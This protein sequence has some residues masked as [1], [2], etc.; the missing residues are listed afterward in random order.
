MTNFY[1]RPPRGGRQVALFGLRVR[2]FISIHALREEGD[3]APANRQ[4]TYAISIHAL[5]EEG[6]AKLIANY[7]IG[8]LF[9]STPS[10]RRA[11]PQNREQ[12]RAA[13][14]FLSTPSARRATCKVVMAMA[15]TFQFL[16]TPSARRATV[17]TRPHGFRPSHF[18]PRPP[19]GGRPPE[20]PPSARTSDF[21]PRPPRGGRRYH[22]Y[23]WNLVDD[24]SIHALREEGDLL[25]GK[26]HHQQAISI[27]AL[28]EEGDRGRLH[29]RLSLLDISIHALREEGDGTPAPIAALWS[30]ISIH[31]LREEGDRPKTCPQYR[32]WLFLSTPSARRATGRCSVA[33]C[34]RAISIHALREEGD[35]MNCE[36]LPTVPY[37]Y[38]RPPRGGRRRR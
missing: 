11:T 8:H 33:G 7:I 27:H 26:A 21:Y 31:A 18:Y 5:R 15:G 19:R 34:G 24:I 9:L 13:R 6:D 20:S 2:S 28:R 25:A 37:F 12:R 1:P 16:S 3:A 4:L 35:R 32:N 36:K 23:D 38:P 29:P 30:R 10:A 14:R 22:L 17:R